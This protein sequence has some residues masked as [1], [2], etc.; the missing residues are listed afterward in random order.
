[1]NL[2]YEHGNINTSGLNADGLEALTL[3]YNYPI[4]TGVT[5]RVEFR[6][7]DWD[8]KTNGSTESVALN[9]VYNF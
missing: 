2:R 9:L 4:W 3:G 6:S 8:G 1:L 5:S 7:D